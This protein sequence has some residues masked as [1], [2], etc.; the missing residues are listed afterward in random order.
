MR[1]SASLT[2]FLSLLSVVIGYL[3]SHAS[4]V[5]KLGIQ[6][7]YSEYDFLRSW[8]KASLVVFLV[9]ILLYAIQTLVQRYATKPVAKIIQVFALVFAVVGLYLSYNDFRHTTTHRW[10]GE[11]FHLGVYLFWLGWMSISIYFLVMKQNIVAL[12]KNIG[13]DV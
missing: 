6:L 8:W 11:R 9:L 7:F 3:L 1:R 12:K 4:W 2:L 13:V 10:M 5:G